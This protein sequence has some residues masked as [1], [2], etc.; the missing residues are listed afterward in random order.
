MT[1]PRNTY[2]DK[3][4]NRR[5]IGEKAVDRYLSVTSALGIL[6][7]EWIAPWYAKVVSENAVEVMMEMREN[8]FLPYWDEQEGEWDYELLAKD[9]ARSPEWERDEAGGLGDAVHEAG[10]RILWASRGNPVVAMEVLMEIAGSLDPEVYARCVGLVTWLEQNEVEV[11]LTEFR[12]FNDTHGYAGS[13]DVLA[14][15]NGHLVFIDLK[16]SKNWDDKFP[17]QISA[18]ANGEYM[19]DAND[20]RVEMPEG[21]EDAKG[22]VM[23]MK[24]NCKTEY[25]EVNIDDEV[26]DGF[27]ACLL[28]KKIWLDI[29]GK[30]QK[31]KKWEVKLDG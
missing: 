13:C 4:G 26:F 15:V 10:E 5:Y 23:W 16:T 9:L 1:E 7:Q 14:R 3:D 30:S 25:W 19:L 2:I 21:S 20:K 22:A 18:Y 17:L 24:V 31:D 12:V 28:L 27:L 6:K 29:T 11:L 8:G